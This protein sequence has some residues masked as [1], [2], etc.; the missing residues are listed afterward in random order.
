[1]LRKKPP[2]APADEAASIV[3]GDLRLANI[4]LRATLT[5]AADG[6]PLAGD[7]AKRRVA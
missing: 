2:H 1:V 4:M 6:A 7:V 3:H 5:R